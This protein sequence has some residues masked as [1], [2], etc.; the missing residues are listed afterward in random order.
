MCNFHKRTKKNLKVLQK[1][2]VHIKFS[3][4]NKRGDEMASECAEERGK[5]TCFRRG[6]MGKARESG[7]TVSRKALAGLRLSVGLA[8]RW[9]SGWVWIDATSVDGIRH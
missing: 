6:E 1:V 8:W 9:S 4:L 7:R 2:D 3:E 5:K